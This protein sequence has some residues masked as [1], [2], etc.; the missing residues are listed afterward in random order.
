MSMKNCSQQCPIDFAIKWACKRNRKNSHLSA[1]QHHCSANHR[2]MICIL[3]TV[4]FFT[5][6]T[7][8]DRKA[9]IL[10]SI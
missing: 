8:I 6:C 4:M 2:M 9:A 10:G 3:L 1:Y 5:V 7:I